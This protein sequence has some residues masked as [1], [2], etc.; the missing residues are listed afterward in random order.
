M[1]LS[2]VHATAPPDCIGVLAADV[3]DGDTDTALPEGYFV[4]PL[5]LDTVH[6]G[7]A[8]P[9]NPGV[10]CGAV[11]AEL[12]PCMLLTMSYHNRPTHVI[13]LRYAS[14]T[15]WVDTMIS[16]STCSFLAERRVGMHE[17]MRVACSLEIV[18]SS[19]MPLLVELDNLEM[20]HSRYLP[21]LFASA[22]I[23]VM[24][25]NVHILVKQSAALSLSTCMLE[26]PIADEHG[27]AYVCAAFKESFMAVLSMWYDESL[28]YTVA[29]STTI[30]LVTPFQC[31][32]DIRVDNPD[33]EIGVL[34]LQ[35][36]ELYPRVHGWPRSRQLWNALM[37][38]L[39]SALRN[40]VR[41]GDSGSCTLHLF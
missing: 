20:Y 17:D 12:Q 19:V 3:P 38:L 13:T 25:H 26:L 4:D 5:R 11:L 24:G 16:E 27:I 6:L 9:E 1:N 31:W 7:P 15:M 18:S 34:L 33:A 14:S 29:S 10:S 22:R 37:G 2:V 21:L 8:F 41:R 36:A 32:S 23:E 35:P 40:L 39:T 30:G 28:C